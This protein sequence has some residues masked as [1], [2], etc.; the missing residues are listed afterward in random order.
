LIESLKAEVG[1]EGERMRELKRK[2]T[3]RDKRR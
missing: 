1:L 3:E 2:G